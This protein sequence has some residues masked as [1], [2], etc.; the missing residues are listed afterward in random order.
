MCERK[1]IKSIKGNMFFKGPGLHI[2]DKRKED[3]K[4]S[5][6]KGW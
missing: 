1:R 3:E 4:C 6:N 2:E 5:K